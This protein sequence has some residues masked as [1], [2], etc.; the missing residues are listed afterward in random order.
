MTQLQRSVVAVS[1]VAAILLGCGG[2]EASNITYNGNRYYGGVAADFRIDAA[3]LAPA[4]DATEV[5][6][7]VKGR[8][9][10]ALSGV[11]AR[12]A[13]VMEPH[14]QS[15][16]YIIFFRSDL[17]GRGVSM[18]SLIDGLCRYAREPPADCAQRSSA[19]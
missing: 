15:L 16:G 8:A 6:A 4:G 14:D 11:D 12:D 19:T 13:V 10:F 9:V 2:S 17:G 3:D 18:Y 1:L 5:R 7:G